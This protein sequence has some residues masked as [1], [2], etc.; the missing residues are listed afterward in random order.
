LANGKR[1]II[2]P[3]SVGSHFVRDGPNGDSSRCCFLDAVFHLAT[4][5]IYSLFTRPTPASPIKKLLEL[6]PRLPADF[7]LTLLT[8]GGCAT[9]PDKPMSQKPIAVT[10]M[11]RE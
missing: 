5:A 9:A 1:R 3:Q 7:I 11:P 8:S 10:P 6:T 2:Q 4:A